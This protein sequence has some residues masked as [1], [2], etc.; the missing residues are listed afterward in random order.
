MLPAL[1]LQQ[2]KYDQASVYCYEYTVRDLKTIS[3]YI[4]QKAN[5]DS[6]N[7]SI[8]PSVIKSINQSVSQLPNHFRD[9]FKKKKNRT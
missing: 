3:Q 4:N 8:N 9:A 7:Q 1:A 5:S 6:I 2:T